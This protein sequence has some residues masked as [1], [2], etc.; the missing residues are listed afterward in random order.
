M[1]YACFT[2]E[3]RIISKVNKNF[4]KTFTVVKVIEW[5]VGKSRIG[6]LPVVSQRVTV[7]QV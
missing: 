3:K 7:S 6:F 2:K 4:Y 1:V 5:W